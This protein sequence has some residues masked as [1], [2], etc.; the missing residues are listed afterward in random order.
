MI[1]RN[2]SIY[3]TLGGMRRAAAIVGGVV[4]GLVTWGA[5]NW[6]FRL[7]W[8]SPEHS[9]LAVIAFWLSNWT[10]VGWAFA[11]LLMYLWYRMLMRL[12]RRRPLE[13]A[14]TNDNAT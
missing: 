14:A 8:Q 1:G 2:F 7:I 10:F 4:L 13:I 3:L 5:L 11:G 6:L 12:A 9:T